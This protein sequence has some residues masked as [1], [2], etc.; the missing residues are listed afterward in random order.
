MGSLLYEKSSLDELSSS[1]SLF[2]NT[3]NQSQL[4][5]ITDKSDSLADDEMNFPGR[6][7]YFLSVFTPCNP[8][9]CYLK[10]FLKNRNS[11]SFK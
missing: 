4:I 11:K 7:L 2:R 10:Q 5:I 3:L 9:V 1:C 8:I 6:I